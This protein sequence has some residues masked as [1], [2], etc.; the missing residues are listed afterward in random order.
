LR[1]ASNDVFPHAVTLKD[2]SKALIRRTRPE[3]FQMLFSMFSLLS[4]ATMFRR[5]LRSQKDLSEQDAREILRLDDRSVTS[6]VAIVRKDHDETAIGEARYVADS[7]GKLAEAAVVIADDWQNRGL[8]TALFSD[9]IAE[10]KRQGLSKV[11]AY[12][13]VDNK[14]IIRVG[15]KVG[16]QL[17]Q[18]EEGTDYSM[19]KAEVVF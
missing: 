3:D 18:R 10:A 1:A 4:T 7:A 11:F 8:G 2:G 19:I 17:A 6:L 14:A 12:F 15:Q 5:F 13:D 9:L 16:F